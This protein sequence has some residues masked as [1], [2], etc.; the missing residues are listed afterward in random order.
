[1]VALIA[2]GPRTRSERYGRT[3]SDRSDTGLHRRGASFVVADSLNPYPTTTRHVFCLLFSVALCFS[4]CLLAHTK[5]DLLSAFVFRVV[6]F[7]CMY[8]HNCQ[9]LA[10]V[11]P[12]R[13]YAQQ[14]MFAV[15]HLSC[16]L[17]RNVYGPLRVFTASTFFYGV[18]RALR[19]PIYACRIDRGNPRDAGASH[20]PTQANG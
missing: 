7:L 3:R 6:L 9:S 5:N 17:H 4:L 18:V 19:S 13:L 2:R 15:H 1:M 11:L 10:H 14:R 8:M 16:A 12:N 20:Q